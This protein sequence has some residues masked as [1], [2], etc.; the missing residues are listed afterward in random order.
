VKLWRNNQTRMGL[1]RRRRLEF[2]AIQHQIRT[3]KDAFTKRLQG[4]IQ[5]VNGCL[6]Y[7][8]TL[9]HKGYA[10]LN[11]RYKGKHVTIHAHR[12]FLILKLGR[13][14]RRGYEAGHLPECE[15]RTCVLHLREEHYSSNASTA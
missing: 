12:L 8:A 5:P 11:V 9:D 3:R 10:R 15:H 2:N 1:A 7:R 4:R 13:P 6:C 14:I